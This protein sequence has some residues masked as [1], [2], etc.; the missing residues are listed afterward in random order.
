[1][2]RHDALLAQEAR[3]VA[4]RDGR[5]TIAFPPELTAREQA[6]RE[7]IMAGIEERTRYRRWVHDAECQAV[8]QLW[9]TVFERRAAS[10]PLGL[11]GGP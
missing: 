2:A 1:M 8:S 10:P 7:H 4:T 9:L 3:L 11:P 6:C 5:D